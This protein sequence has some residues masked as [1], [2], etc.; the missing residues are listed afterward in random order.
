MRNY[1]DEH[2]NI[3]ED[4]IQIERAHRIRGKKSPQDVRNEIMTFFLGLSILNQAFF[5]K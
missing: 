1:L 2:L 4:S 3:D 5:F